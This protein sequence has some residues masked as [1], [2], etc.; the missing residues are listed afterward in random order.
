MIKRRQAGERS[1]LPT[2][3][4]AKLGHLREQERSGA[5]TDA[6]DSGEFLCFYAERLVLR[7]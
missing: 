4:L 7:D 2:I 5:H 6:A 3:E 1:G